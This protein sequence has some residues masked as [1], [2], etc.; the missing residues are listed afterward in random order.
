MAMDRLLRAQVTKEVRAVM[1]KML[2]GYGETYLTAKELTA[3]FQMLS[4]EWLKRY[5]HLLPRV[6]A[7]VTDADGKEHR[8]GWGYAR[9][10]I[11]R[12]IEDGSIERLRMGG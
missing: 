10:K 9:N 3:Q 5:G 6:Q 4:P 1:E 8:T 7:V 11:A 2:E 12:M